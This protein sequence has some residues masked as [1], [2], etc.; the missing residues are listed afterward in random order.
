M[1]NIPLFV[2]LG[3]PLGIGMMKRVI[4]QLP[5]FPRPPIAEWINGLREDDFV[6]LGRE[7]ETSNLGFSGIINISR[8]LVEEDDKHAVSAYLRS[9][10]ICASIHAAVTDG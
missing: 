2:T 6:T 3:S 7:L 8:D 1:R 5:E 9:R 10:P 4:R